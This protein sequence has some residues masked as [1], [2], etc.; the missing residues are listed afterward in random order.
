M[1]CDFQA[2]SWLVDH[3]LPVNRVDDVYVWVCKRPRL[4]GLNSFAVVGSVHSSRRK[5]PSIYG[6]GLDHL[7]Q[8]QTIGLDVI[9]RL[10][11]ISA[12]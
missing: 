6:H 3:G 8:G 10:V 1:R 5:T 7:W 9:M 2:D 12:V 4:S 11:H